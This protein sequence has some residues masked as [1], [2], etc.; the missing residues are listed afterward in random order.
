MH[1]RCDG[2]GIGAGGAVLGP[3]RRIGI[4]FGQVFDDCQGFPNCYGSI[5]QCRQFGGRRILEDGGAGARFTQWD[6]H[7]FEGDIDELE[8]KP[9]AQRP[10]RIGFVGDAEND[11]GHNAFPDSAGIVIREQGDWRKI[12]G[13][14]VIQ[15]FPAAAL[16]SS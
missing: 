15:A 10:L 7:F 11:F 16:A 8:G 13:G 3:E 5:N 1:F 12:V 6:N 14:V 2:A 9:A 4:F